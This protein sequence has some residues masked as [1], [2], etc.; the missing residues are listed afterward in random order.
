[1]SDHSVSSK[2]TGAAQNAPGGPK[3]DSSLEPPKAAEVKEGPKKNAKIRLTGAQRKRL[4]YLLDKGWDIEEARVKCLE[5]TTKNTPKPKGEKRGRSD[6]STPEQRKKSKVPTKTDRPKTPPAQDRSAPKP[7]FSQ[8]LTGVRVGILSAHYP[9]ELLTMEQLS[10]LQEAILDKIVESKAPIKPKF[11]SVHNRPGW[12][13]LLCVNSE[14]A[15]WLKGVIGE[16]KPWDTAN[17][18]VVEESELPHPEIL[19]AYLPMS[20]DYTTEKIFGLIEAQNDLSTSN[21]KVL[22]RV[23]TGQAEEVAISIDHASS[24]ALG[25]CGHKINYKFGLVQLRPKGKKAQE[26]S[27]AE[28][29]QTVPPLI[30]QGASK[31]SSSQ[32]TDHKGEAVPNEKSTD[33]G[34]DEKGA[35]A[36]A[37]I[38]QD[39]IID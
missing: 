4:K 31:P 19:I 37:S 7:A 20:K 15:N 29:A 32:V 35:K 16:I 10:A 33:K 2:G 34:K 28:I 9:E 39:M 38:A 23:T 5:P 12:L 18:R 8:V 13:A 22:R 27:K 36:E 14:T 6:F 11:H 1:M 3:A 21:W 24:V 17:L 30:E 26:A 25:K